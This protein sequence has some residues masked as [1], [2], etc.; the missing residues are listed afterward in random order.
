M[1]FE[2]TLNVGD[3][4]YNLH[5]FLLQIGQNEDARGRIASRPAWGL[6]LEMD[7]LDDDTLKDWMVNPT[8]QKDG[9]VVLNRIDE[10]D[11]QFKQIEFRRAYCVMYHDIFHTYEGY[12]STAL[13]ITGEELVLN[14]AALRV[15]NP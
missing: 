1:A 4:H 2:A 8:M 15:N 6:I 14:T 9:S 11:A 5:W 12:M 10:A 3:N 13:Y 7:T